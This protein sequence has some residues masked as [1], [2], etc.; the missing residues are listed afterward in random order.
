MCKIRTG[1][2]IRNAEDIRSMITAV[3]LRQQ[4]RYSKEDIYVSVKKFLNGGP[5]LVSDKTLGNMI[6]RNLDVF[7]HTGEI[8]C[9]NGYYYPSRLV[10]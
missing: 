3:I 7:S 8:R 2:K 5:E 9:R 1:E 4:S 10:E 6:E